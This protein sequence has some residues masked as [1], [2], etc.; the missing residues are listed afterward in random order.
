MQFAA[1][2][3]CHIPSFVLLTVHLEFLFRFDAVMHQIRQILPR[4]IVDCPLHTMIY[5]QVDCQYMYLV[6]VEGWTLRPESQC[7][8][9][10]N[11]QFATR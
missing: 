10:G 2:I 11:C 7:N 1:H 5:I 6:P 3:P 4:R 9:R 8:S